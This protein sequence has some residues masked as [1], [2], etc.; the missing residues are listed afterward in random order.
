[1][2]KVISILTIIFL[3][4]GT[5]SQVCYTT[6]APYKT[7]NASSVSQGFTSCSNGDAVEITTYFAAYPFVN[8][9]IV[10]NVYNSSGDVIGTTNYTGDAMIYDYN[11][12]QPLPQ[13]TI[14]INCS[15]Y[16]GEQYRWEINQCCQTDGGSGLPVYIVIQETSNDQIAGSTIYQFISPQGV[17]QNSFTIQKEIKASV[18]ILR[19]EEPCVGDFNND[20]VVDNLDAQIIAFQYGKGCE[21]ITADLDGDCD[22]DDYDL[23]L[24]KPLQGTDCN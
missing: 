16:A 3:T 15:I 20:G 6:S 4:L 14:T 8:D 5:N 2:K 7:A 18:R 19:H 23:Y 11:T 17:Q 1:M 12:P 13:V 10:F 21:F 22:V 24:F 9:W